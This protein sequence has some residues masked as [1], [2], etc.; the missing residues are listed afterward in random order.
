MEVMRQFPQIHLAFEVRP[1]FGLRSV[2]LPLHTLA[3]NP[4]PRLLTWPP[5]AKGL[6][7]TRREGVR[8]TPVLSA[9]LAHLY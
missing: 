3:L 8:L 6:R 1:G 7:A 4:F 9:T 2:L 5:L